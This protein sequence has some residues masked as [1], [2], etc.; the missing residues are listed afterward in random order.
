M[1]QMILKYVSGFIFSYYNRES[2]L[3]HAGFEPH[4]DH[5]I[6]QKILTCGVHNKGEESLTYSCTLINFAAKPLTN[7]NMIENMT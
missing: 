6:D 7:N 2:K 4:F 5:V 3:I 1:I